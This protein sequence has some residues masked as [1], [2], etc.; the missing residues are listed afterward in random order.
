MRSIHRILVTTRELWPLFAG[1]T[2]GAITITG[3]TLLV[4]FIIA[5][6]IDVVVAMV[7]GT[8]GS[9][10]ELVWLA[11]WILVVSLANSVLTNV[12]GYWGDLAAARLRVILSQRYYE[13]L[14]RLPL[15]YYDNELTGTIISRL[16][17]SITAVTDFLK[18]FAGAFFPLVLTVTAVLVITGLHSPCCCCWW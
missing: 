10:T 13:K 14:L 7:Q 4:P 11:V 9:T 15:S 12:T 2:L 1:I 17:R 18:T 6:A 5:R 8:G 16:N 3:T